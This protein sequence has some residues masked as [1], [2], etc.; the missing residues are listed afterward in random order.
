MLGLATYVANPKMLTYIG[1]CQKPNKRCSVLAII[2]LIYFEK[3]KGR[4]LNLNIKAIILLLLKCFLYERGD[5]ILNKI[6]YFC[7]LNIDNPSGFV[8]K[9]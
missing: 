3:A 1:R 6:K 8:N 9:P 7:V 2:G 5:R 4:A